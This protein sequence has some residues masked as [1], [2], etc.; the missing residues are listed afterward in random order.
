VVSGLSLANKSLLLFG[1]AA[2][3]ILAGALSVPWFRTRM[4]IED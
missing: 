3:V 1:C 2:V 4:M